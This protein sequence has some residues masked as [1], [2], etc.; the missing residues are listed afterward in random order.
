MASIP[1]QAANNCSKSI[2][3][4]ND[5]IQM[6]RH[7]EATFALG[8]SGKC[9]WS[10]SEAPLERAVSLETHAWEDLGF[11]NKNESVRA[12]GMTR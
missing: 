6:K 3:Q 1:G 8:V 10:G 4:M 2:D 5:S 7:R 12:D 11:A 9:V